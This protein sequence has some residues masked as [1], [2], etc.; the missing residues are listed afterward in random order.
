VNAIHAFLNS[1]VV[2][3]W[4]MMVLII[5]FVVGII[6]L[7]VRG[8]LQQAEEIKYLRQRQYQ[9]REQPSW[10]PELIQYW[11]QFADAS[12]TVVDQRIA[13]C[14]CA[15]DM[16]EV[17][18]VGFLNFLIRKATKKSPDELSK[19]NRDLLTDGLPSGGKTA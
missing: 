11:H 17:A 19:A 8:I 15:A 1:P 6:F 7:L 2:V 9:Q 18:E 4:F 16:Q 5:I 14:R 10:L 3:P 12:T 13:T